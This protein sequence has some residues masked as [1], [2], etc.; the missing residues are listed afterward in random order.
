M[1]SVLKRLKINQS[2]LINFNHRI[3]ASSLPS[4]PTMEDYH[5]SHL[6]NKGLVAGVLDG[7]FSNHCAC[8]LSKSLPSYIDKYGLLEGFKKQ[9]SDLISLVSQIDTKNIHKLSVETK[10]KLMEKLLPA[11]SGSCG[12]A[13]TFFQ[14]RLNIANLGDCRAILG[15]KN[16]NSIKATFLT[17]DHQPGNPKEYER[18]LNEHKGEITACFDSGDGVLRVLGC[19]LPSRFVLLKIGHLGTEDLNGI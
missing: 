13:A 3:H 10:M 8:F 12:V 11:F 17:E 6:L 1:K 18:L 4:N 15:S 7:H 16:S 14:D 9:D 5:F 2:N 19:L